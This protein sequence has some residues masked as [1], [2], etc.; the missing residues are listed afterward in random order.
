MFSYFIQLLDGMEYLHSHSIIHKDLKPGNL[1]LTTDETLKIIDLGV[2]EVAMALTHTVILKHL[3]QHKLHKNYAAELMIFVTVVLLILQ[4][5]VVITLWI[6]FV[7]FSNWITC[8]VQ[9][10]SVVLVKAP[11]LSNH[12]KLL[13]VM[14]LFPVSRSIYGQQAWRCKCIKCIF[15]VVFL[16]LKSTLLLC[17]FM[18]SS[19]QLDIWKVRAVFYR[20]LFYVL[21]LILQL[22][23][24]PSKGIPYTNYMK[25]YV[26]ETTRFQKP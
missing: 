6:W 13:M 21:D 7:V 9:V 3:Q 5:R 4:H 16:N 23:D 14:I 20:V 22:A 19:T 24:I 10:T 12:L 25:I 17:T 11:L 1:L 15:I 2:A 18:H 8:L 26:K